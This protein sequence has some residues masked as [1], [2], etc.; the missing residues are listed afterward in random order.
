[1]EQ[2]HP[3]ATLS[4]LNG[5]T[6]M[7]ARIRAHDW[8]PTPLG[9]VEAWPGALRTALGICLGI[10]A[11]SA[12]LWGHGPHFLYND[13]WAAAV[14]PEKHPGALG[15]PAAEVWPE[16]WHQL[17]SIFSQMME[18][19]DGLLT[20]QDNLALLH[21]EPATAPR[22]RF[23]STAIR[24]E[25]GAFGGVLKQAYEAPAVM[26]RT[27][28]AAF[29]LALSDQLKQLADPDEMLTAS[30]R[31]LSAHL[32][33]SGAGFA[34]LLP[35]GETLRLEN[36]TADGGAHKVMAGL[37]FPPL[38][39]ASLR[40]GLPV[41]YVDVATA[42][43]FRGSRFAGSAIRA[44]ISAP[45]RRDGQL[46]A[47]LYAVDRAPRGWT[48][49]EV[50]LTG[51]VADRLWDAVEQAHADQAAL[52]ES[53]ALATLNRVGRDIAA[54]RDLKSLI[55][56]F[57]EAAAQLAGAT[58]VAYFERTV[59]PDQAEL[60]QL[61]ALTG[62]PAEAFTR[63]GLPR[64]TTL[65][66]PT[67]LG[68]GPV[69][70]G[71]I[72]RDPR[73]G[74]LGGLPEGH[75]PVRSYL[76]LPVV[77]SSGECLGALL[78]GAAEPDLF[79]EREERLISGLAGVTSVAIDN[80]RLLRATQDEV[81]ER[82]KAEVALRE[83]NNTLEERID[84]HT[85][86]LMQAEAQLRQSQKME[87]VG[88]LTGGI[89]HDFNNLLTGIAGNLEML[90]TRLQQGRAGDAEPYIA[91]AQG[92]ARR[93]AALTHRLLAFSRRQ[94]LDPRAIDINR[95]VTDMEELIRRSVGPSITVEVVGAATL[96][97]TFVDPNQ[98]EN[99]L[100]NLCLNARDAM[101]A[102]GRLTLE[103]ANRWLDTE[104]ARVREL[105]PGQYISLSVSDNGTGMTPEVV[106]RA[107]DPFFTTKPLGH[108]TGLGLSMIYG[109]ARQSG[110]QARIHSQPDKGTTVALYLPRDADAGAE[111]IAPLPAADT[112]GGSGQTILI[113]DD[114]PTVRMLITELLGDRGFTMLEA[115]DAPTG[116]KLLQSPA[117][118]DLLISDVGLPGGMNG[119]QMADAART[120][121]PDLKVL[122]ITGYAENAVISH[123]HL[124]PGMHVLTKPFAME[125]LAIARQR[126]D[127]DAVPRRQAWRPALSRG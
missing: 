61:Y 126:P 18:H 93:A 5:G 25:S 115:H 55:Q 104:A 112:A 50:A 98:L 64:Q 63:F 35:D 34:R 75:L 22:W 52:E 23:S 102:G 12:I 27:P 38:N 91:A 123:G 29:L 97:R 88:Q 106:H 1:M 114:E 39:L 33:I 21:G 101:P 24:H 118:I 28:R 41:S 120:T 11:P 122:F 124:D 3:A 105:P 82:T 89:A 84:R 47:V 48:E 77:S 10:S 43:E 49:D 15:K 87:A 69:R 58:Y 65:F 68:Q 94:T 7:G 113:V 19:G 17:A 81:A 109:F 32:R 62:A 2:A 67:F 110:G 117:R 76:A 107:F 59:T 42:P 26:H 79:G 71:D 57:I 95:L 99:A 83:L 37:S 86:A 56:L 121:R 74:S 4:F 46:K 85:D 16:H 36:V 96:W 14:A 73:Y 20:F 92:A 80:A 72:T 60:W 108:G 70:S 78:L 44:L 6:E 90:Q 13:A 31:A 51:D 30:F 8:S 125:T 116:L 111:D 54:Q 103:T 100:L 40:Q 45:V 127:R 119:R 53:R 9:P 66:T